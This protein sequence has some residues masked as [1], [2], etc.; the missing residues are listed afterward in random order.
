MGGE[1]G[2][3]GKEDE[4]LAAP[5]VLYATGCGN[6]AGPDFPSTIP[7]TTL[8]VVAA[9]SAM[10][11]ARGVA[12]ANLTRLAL[13]SKAAAWLAATLALCSGVSELLSKSSAVRLRPLGTVSEGA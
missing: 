4:E 2:G 6:S 3:P 5:L 12:L 13:A 7:S 11:R 10:A 8:T 1:A 9:G